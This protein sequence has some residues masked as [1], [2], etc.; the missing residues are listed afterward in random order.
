MSL[1]ETAIEGTLKP[2]GTRKMDEKRELPAGRVQ[3]VV[4][5]LPK[6]IPSR[7]GLVEIMDENPTVVG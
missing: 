5:P 1:T 7:R 4:H 2:D 3:V 6:P